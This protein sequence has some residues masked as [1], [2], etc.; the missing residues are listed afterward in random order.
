MDQCYPEMQQVQIHL[1]A[2][3]NTCFV[4]FYCNAVDETSGMNRVEMFVND[5]LYEIKEG[6]GP[7]Y[8]FSIEW[9]NNFSDAT[10]SFYHYDN[11]GN[12]V[13]DE[14]WCNRPIYEISKTIIGFIRNPVITEHNVTFYPIFVISII[15]G[16][17]N[18]PF[19]NINMFKPM[20]YPNSYNGHI[21]RHYICATFSN[22]R[23]W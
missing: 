2:K 11:A 20:N 7:N 16:L 5:E 10:F 21:G 19:I 8:K 17:N 22:Y 23:F 1:Y 14:L 9:F 6:I 13:W 3:N 12:M 18:I 4:E 15:V